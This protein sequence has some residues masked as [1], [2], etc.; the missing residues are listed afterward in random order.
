MSVFRIADISA[1]RSERLLSAR[2]AFRRTCICSAQF[3]GSKGPPLASCM[4]HQIGSVR[5]ATGVFVQ[6][7]KLAG[8]MPLVSAL[9]FN[10][11]LRFEGDV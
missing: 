5:S 9:L 4:S 3:R 6:T 11:A 7:C 1:N 8:A 10:A 2:S